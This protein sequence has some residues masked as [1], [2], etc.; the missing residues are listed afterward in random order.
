MKINIMSWNIAGAKVFGKLN[1]QPDTVAKDYIKEY[2]QVWE[3]EVKNYFSSHVGSSNLPD[4]ILLQEC[5]G[6]IDNRVP[7]NISKRWIS[8]KE[9]LDSIFNDYECFFFPALS[10]TKNPHP[11][12]WDK[13]RKGDKYLPEFIE[14]QQGYG[15]CVKNKNMLR[16]LWTKNPLE[17]EHHDKDYELDTIENEKYESCFQAIPI[18]TGLYLGTRDTEPR[19]AILG[20]M[21]LNPNKYLNFVNLHLTT[22]KGE[23]EGKIRINQQSSQIRMNQINLILNFIISAYQESDLYR[24]NSNIRNEDIWVVA[25]DFNSIPESQEI[26]LMKEVGFIDGN[27]N[28]KL[29]APELK[30]YNA[31]EGTKWSL[32]NENLPPIALDYIFC[33]IEKSSFTSGKINTTN[34]L[35]PFRPNFQDENYQSDHAVL[36]SV[37]EFEDSP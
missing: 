1:P 2:H 3:N 4:I 19:L 17:N 20:R 37:F 31:K 5:I 16:K 14:A 25:G 30:H 9:I 21:K 23:R 13:Y 35:Q 8:G 29:I 18:S 27:V 15:L 32:D 7:D 28:K 12:K 33:G 10:S 24:I 11:R 6:F 34:S 36:Y 22:L 26:S